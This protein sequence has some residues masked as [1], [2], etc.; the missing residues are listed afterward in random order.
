MIID[1][2]ILLH[3]ISHCATG[4]FRYVSLYDISRLISHYLIWWNLPPFEFFCTSSCLATIIHWHDSTSVYKMVQYDMLPQCS[5][6]HPRSS[7]FN[8]PQTRNR[9]YVLMVQNHLLEGG[10]LDGFL[11]LV[12]QVL[13]NAIAQG[14]SIYQVREYVNYT[15]PE[16]HLTRCPTSKVQWPDL[17]KLQLF[18]FLVPQ[19]VLDDSRCRI[20]WCCRAVF[21]KLILTWKIIWTI[22]AP[23]WASFSG[24]PFFTHVDGKYRPFSEKN[25]WPWRLILLSEV[26][27]WNRI[28]FRGGKKPEKSSLER[29]CHPE[30]NY[31][32]KSLKDSEDF[33]NSSEDFINSSEDFINSPKRTLPF[34]TIY[35]ILGSIYSFFGLVGGPCPGRAHVAEI[36]RHGE[37]VLSWLGNYEGG[38]HLHLT[39]THRE[40]AVFEPEGAEHFGY[41]LWPSRRNPARSV[42]I[43]IRDPDGFFLWSS[44]HEWVIQIQ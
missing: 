43:G 22:R 16:R 27:S 40:P 3:V 39:P 24:A 14:S 4:Q 36:E 1:S 30:H 6:A 29:T 8:C 26:I 23:L 25:I 17:V 10:Q 2:D 21:A 44:S 38:S 19:G 7:K 42:P 41:S 12:H 31:P 37:A 34:R 5:V 13:P 33:T 35:K 28:F 11:H 18:M 32:A 20:M 15:I 9:I